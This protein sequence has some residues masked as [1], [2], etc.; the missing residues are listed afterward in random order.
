MGGTF[1]QGY[2]SGV[3][4]SNLYIGGTGVYNLT[5]GTLSV[6]NGQEVLGVAGPEST[7]NQEGG[8]H[9]TSLLS[10]LTP[11]TYDLRGGQ[12]GGNVQISGGTRNQ[13]GGDP[14]P[15]V[16]KGEVGWVVSR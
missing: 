14:S 10:I 9:Y 12:L 16:L 1:N 3:T 15:D 2:F 8:F 13:T 6:V 4:V 7:F 11:G 5:N